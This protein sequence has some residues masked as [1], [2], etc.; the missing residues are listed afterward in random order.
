[1]S[2]TQFRNARSNSK[3]KVGCCVRR[4]RV[5]VALGSCARAGL[6]PSSTP[7]LPTARLSPL[8]LAA[9]TALSKAAPWGLTFSKAPAYHTE[10]A[11][12]RCNKANLCARLAVKD[13]PQKRCRKTPYLFWPINVTDIL[14]EVCVEMGPS[15]W[16]N[17]RVYFT[18]PERE[19]C[20][21]RNKK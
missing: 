13:H 18:L 8:P 16:V 17:V 9:E 4:G 10:I 2:H 19:L 7:A 1:M 3:V 20:F 14:L 6:A 5:W 12:R 11:S 21:K 15:K